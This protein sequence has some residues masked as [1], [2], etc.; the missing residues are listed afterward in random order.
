[1][2][3]EFEPRERCSP[4]EIRCI[5]WAQPNRAVEPIPQGQHGCFVPDPSVGGILKAIFE[6]RIYSPRAHGEPVAAWIEK[7]SPKN[8]GTFHL[9]PGSPRYYL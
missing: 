5:D 6:P 8:S 9:R 7:R 4:D 1:M 3:I 2:K